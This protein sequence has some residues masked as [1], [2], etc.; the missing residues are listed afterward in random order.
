MGILFGLQDALHG[1]EN[2]LALAEQPNFA[3]LL[4]QNLC[5]GDGPWQLQ[6]G[7]VGM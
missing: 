2:V 4:Q 6:T 7:L 5:D 1:F 3:S